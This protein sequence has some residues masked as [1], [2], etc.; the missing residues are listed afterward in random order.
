MGGYGY[1]KEYAVEQIRRD[2]R[3]TTIYEGT[4]EIMQWTVSRDRWRIHLQERGGFYRKMAESLEALHREDNQVGADVAALAVRAVLEITERCRVGRLTRNQ[5]VLFQL[6]ELMS[7]AEI[8]AN[9]ARYAAGRAPEKYAPFFA[10]SVVKVMSR[11][12]ARD[13][14][15]DVLAGGVRLVRG[16][17]AVDDAA[18]AE[19]ERALQSSAIHASAKGLM[20][21]LEVVAKAIVEQDAALPQ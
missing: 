4:S 7:R 20:A 6:G 9:F 8:A 14:A 16:M 11:I 12:C 5:H 13:T 10:P 1:T 2:V 17:D 18:M 15:L 3:I 19:F 21:D